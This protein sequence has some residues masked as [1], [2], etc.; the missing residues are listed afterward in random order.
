MVVARREVL[1]GEIKELFV[2]L[3]VAV[4]LIL[5]LSWKRENSNFLEKGE[6]RKYEQNT[7]QRQQS[8]F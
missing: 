7:N 5:S 2:I 4:Q 3:F 8:S 1:F 6:I